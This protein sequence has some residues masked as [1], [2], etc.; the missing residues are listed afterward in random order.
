MYLTCMTAFEGLRGKVD[1]STKLILNFGGG[2]PPPPRPG[3][4]GGGGGGG[5]VVY[6]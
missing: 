3:G 5:V 6:V 4:G 1:Q 2:G